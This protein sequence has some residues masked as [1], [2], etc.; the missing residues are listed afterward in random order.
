MHNA[1]STIFE[2]LVV[3]NLATG[4]SIGT[5]ATTVDIKTTFNIN[6]TTA[7]Q[8]LTLPNPT[9]TTAGRVV[10]VNNVG[11]VGFIMLG[12]RVESSQSRQAIWNGTTW[13]W[14]GDQAGTSQIYIQK[15]IQETVTNTT[16]LQND[17]VFTFAIGAN[18]TWI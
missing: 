4:G 17:D 7:S 2:A 6:Q 5:A 14:I 18:E 13:K 3:S 15:A 10:Y 12:E 11:T 9:N 1:G 16:T 8:T